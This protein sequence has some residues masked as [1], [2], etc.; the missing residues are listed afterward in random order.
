VP[1]TRVELARYPVVTVPAM[2]MDRAT[3]PRCVGLDNAT[4]SL[5]TPTSKM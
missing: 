5:H 3:G 1:S 2:L 4:H